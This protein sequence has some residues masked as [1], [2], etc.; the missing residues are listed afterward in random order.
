MCCSLKYSLFLAVQPATHCTCVLNGSSLLQTDLIQLQLG[1]VV[2]FG[3]EA[4]RIA[5]IC[6]GSLALQTQRNHLQISVKDVCHKVS[7]GSTARRHGASA[8]PLA[9]ATRVAAVLHE[10]YLVWIAGVYLLLWW[11]RGNGYVLLR[12]FLQELAEYSGTF[13]FLPLLLDK[14]IANPRQ[15]TAHSPQQLW[16]RCPRG[17]PRSHSRALDCNHSAAAKLEGSARTTACIIHTH[18]HEKTQRERLYERTWYGRRCSIIPGMQYL[19]YP[20]VRAKQVQ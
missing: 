1:A 10:H 4:A 18:V 20:K 8:S 12:F 9:I 7:P 17:T 15:P 2:V 5:G 19:I 11:Q 14:T 13:E 16:S 3:R 6:C